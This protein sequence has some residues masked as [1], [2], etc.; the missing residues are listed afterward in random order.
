M[1]HHW[2]RR[3]ASSGR[4]PP[5]S[6]RRYLPRAPRLTP[7]SLAGSPRGPHSALDAP[8]ALPAAIAAPTTSSPACPRRPH[9]VSLAAAGSRCS[10]HHGLAGAYKFMPEIEHDEAHVAA[11]DR[12]P[13]ISAPLRGYNVWRGRERE[14]EIAEKERQERGRGLPLEVAAAMYCVRV[15]AGEAAAACAC[16]IVELPLLCEAHLCTFSY[17]NDDYL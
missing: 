13:T 7:R 12:S 11:V 5:P 9:E 8:A 15:L 3:P 10:C 1:F 14:R 2:N 16:S 4:K 6:P 17:L